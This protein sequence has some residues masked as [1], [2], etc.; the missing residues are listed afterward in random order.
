MADE[1]EPNKPAQNLERRKRI[2]LRIVTGLV[3]VAFVGFRFYSYDREWNHHK[4]K[5][6]DVGA[7]FREDLL[8]NRLDG[9]HEATTASFKERWSRKDLEEM[10]GQVSADGSTQK[11]GWSIHGSFWS[12]FSRGHLRTEY[13]IALK[14][15][16]GSHGKL[17]LT[18]VEEDGV[19]RVDQ[20][21][22]V[23]NEQEE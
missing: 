5:G 23:E 14:V 16:D 9:A 6:Y 1:S 4:E 7:A 3:V 13:P 22:V 2:V 12:N 8:K 18:I 19:L 10:A 21:E 20:M 11:F 17:R 15:K